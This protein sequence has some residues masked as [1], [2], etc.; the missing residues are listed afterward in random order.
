M[1][2]KAARAVALVAYDRAEVLDDWAYNSGRK[3][4]RPWEM[5][6]WRGWKLRL[7]KNTFTARSARGSVKLRGI[8]SVELDGFELER[9]EWE[10]AALAARSYFGRAFARFTLLSVTNVLSLK[11]RSCL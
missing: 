5:P 8:E 2:R 9:L 6:R 4:S 11:K 10:M 1:V 7:A 3:F